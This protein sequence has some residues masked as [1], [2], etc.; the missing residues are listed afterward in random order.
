MSSVGIGILKSVMAQNL[1]FSEIV[2]AGIDDTFLEG[3]EIEAYNFVKTFKYKHDKYPKFDTV[4]AEVP[5]ISFSG[6]PEEPVEYWASELKVRKQF[7]ILSK[8]K[9][10]LTSLLQKNKVAEAAKELKLVNDDLLRV[11]Q[12]FTVSDLADLQEKVI[13][14]HD[15]VQRTAG[16][17]GVPYG[18]PI[19][20]EITGG[21][22]EA[23][24]NVII[25]QTGSC[26]SYFCIWAAKAAHSQGKNVMV[27]SPEMPPEQVARRTLAMQLEVPDG[28]I[29]KGRLSCFAIEKA[30]RIIKEPISIE[31]ETQD[32]WF[33]ILP[34]GLYSDVN[35]VISVASEYKP[36]LLVVDGFY[37][38]KNGKLRT[39]SSWAEDESVIFLLKNFAINSNMPILASTQYNRAKPGKLEGA[40]GT[41]GTE[42]V[43]SNFLSLEFESPADRESQQPIQ[44]RVLKS[45]KSRDGDSFV[46]K[47]EFNFHK[48][49]IKEMIMTSGNIDSEPEFEDS[50]YMDEI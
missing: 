42:Q 39:T 3:A 32:N 1:P 21:Q 9:D 29:R 41:Q 27:I 13:D 33:K 37:L 10:R 44:T 7:W 16:I 19:L 25:G 14:R 12:E 8:I 17:S 48:T 26:K 15:V 11:N 22:Q 31:G 4:T 30:R 40:R 18:F 47:Y 6:L 45:K 46:I 2:E 38:L 50:Q 34:S 28:S 35:Q 24:F 43:A 20:D 23:D 49:Q 5:T 36:D